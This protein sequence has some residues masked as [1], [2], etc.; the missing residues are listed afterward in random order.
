M[1]A[2]HAEVLEMRNFI[3]EGPPVIVQVA[4]PTQKPAPTPDI[5]P[6]TSP[7]SP[8]QANAN[9]YSH[10]TLSLGDLTNSAADN[11]TSSRV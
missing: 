5:V 3:N 4:A 1:K 11:L 7:T 2:I 9:I 8:I 6:Q 10:S